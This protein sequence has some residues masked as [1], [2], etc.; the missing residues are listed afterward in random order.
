MCVREN[1]VGE[2]HTPQLDDLGREWRLDLS[3]KH[4]KRSEKSLKCLKE[5]ELEN[6][7]RVS[8]LGYDSGKLWFRKLILQGMETHRTVRSKR[9]T[10]P[11]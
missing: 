9:I 11:S 6:R 3:E 1:E 4:L 8:E 2:T 10:Y 7:R 5:L